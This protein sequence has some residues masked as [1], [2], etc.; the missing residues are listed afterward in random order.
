MRN[1]ILYGNRDRAGKEVLKDDVRLSYIK[2]T[3]N[4][5]ASLPLECRGKKKG[6]YIDSPLRYLY[7]F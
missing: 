7:E 1:S 6:E 3:Q 4:S 5:H 2:V